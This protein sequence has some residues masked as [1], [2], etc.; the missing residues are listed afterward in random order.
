MGWVKVIILVYACGPR[1]TR[2]ENTA[3]TWLPYTKKKQNK[4]GNIV[5]AFHGTA[6]NCEHL[7]IATL[8]L[9]LLSNNH[10]GFEPGTSS[11]QSKVW[12]HIR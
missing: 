6:F 11:T 4:N 5:G 3:D 2:A 7:L 1:N 10:S 9:H 12:L 8:K